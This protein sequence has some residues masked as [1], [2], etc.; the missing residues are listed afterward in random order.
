[1]REAPPLCKGRRQQGTGR[2]GVRESREDAAAIDQLKTE[3]ALLAQ[4]FEFERKAW[5]QAQEGQLTE[6]RHL[7]KRQDETQDQQLA[8]ASGAYELGEKVRME[9]GELTEQARFMQAQLERISGQQE[10]QQETLDRLEADVKDMSLL[11]YEIYDDLAQRVDSHEHQLSQIGST[12][13]QQQDQLEQ[14]LTGVQEFLAEGL[15]EAT[16][17]ANQHADALMEL[18]A[19]VADALSSND[20][21]QQ[22]IGKRQET[23]QEHLFGQIKGL[24]SQIEA[25]A[26]KLDERHA[27]LSGK[28][29][30]ALKL[31]HALQSRFDDSQLDVLKH[32]QAQAA[33]WDEL[34]AAMTK[35]VGAH[36]TDLQERLQRQDD[37]HLEMQD[38]L[39][40][41]QG[42]VHGEITE[43]QQGVSQLGTQGQDLVRV[44]DSVQQGAIQSEQHAAA[45]MQ[46]QLEAFRATLEGMQQIVEHAQATTQRVHSQAHQQLRA[47]ESKTVQALTHQHQE[48][49]ERD[50]QIAALRDEYSQLS[51]RVGSILQLLMNSQ[52]GGAPTF[53]P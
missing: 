12:L 5:R 34:A 35:R 17:A 9:L 38:W 50:R 14:G 51:N 27:E 47:L 43:L 45:R 13:L 49:L 31:H 19:A 37:R 10:A 18:K 15:V 4:E 1:M 40:H 20:A 7:V 21:M 41:F 48:T 39:A 16:E 52:R 32:Q 46:S 42:T 33:Q 22:A 30:E 3:L 6:F 29:V 36:A 2:I 28:Q 25:L 23:L 26:S 11:T 8:I 44:L 24:H 53:T